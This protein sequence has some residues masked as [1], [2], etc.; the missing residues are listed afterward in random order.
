LFNVIYLWQYYSKALSS[1]LGSKVRDFYTQTHKQVMDI[2]EEAR[3]LAA[4]QKA[5]T[6]ST[7]ST[8]TT[9][10]PAET[11]VASS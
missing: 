1:P 10:K 11:P 7:P 5:A 6:A 8:A 4:E 2:H 9:E 3:R